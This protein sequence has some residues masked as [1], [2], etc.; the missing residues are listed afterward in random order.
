MVAKARSQRSLGIQHFGYTIPSKA[1]CCGHGRSSP[2]IRECASYKEALQL[3]TDEARILLK[4]QQDILD[5]VRRQI[6]E[7]PAKVLSFKQ[8]I[9]A[10]F[11]GDSSAGIRATLRDCSNSRQIRLL[12]KSVAFT[13][14]GR[15]KLEIVAQAFDRGS[16]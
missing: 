11:P 15:A 5:K 1:L 3:A 16:K 2:L 13:D 12:S 4:E 14:L 9:L 7:K 8:E 10:Q 6:N